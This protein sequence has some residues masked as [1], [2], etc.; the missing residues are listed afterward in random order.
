MA[1]NQ[2][3]FEM[4]MAE[5]QYIRRLLEQ[6]NGRVRDNTERIVAL[7]SKSSVM[8]GVQAG[9]SLLLSAVAAYL[10]VKY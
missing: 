3:D 9:V 1:G 4:I 8:A 7:E 2:T 10:G 5:L 6:Q